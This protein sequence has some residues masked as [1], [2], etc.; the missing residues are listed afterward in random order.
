MRGPRGGRCARRF[1]T[2]SELQ[3]NVALSLEDVA[4]QFICQADG[5]LGEVTDDEILL[6]DLSHV[7]N[8]SCWRSM[9]YTELR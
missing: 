7:G 3:L 9:G 4:P 8:A 2:R 1:E 5:G 6:G